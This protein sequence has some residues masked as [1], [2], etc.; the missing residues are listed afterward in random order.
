MKTRNELELYLHIPFCVRKCHYCDFLSFAADERTQQD[1]AYAL[2]Q[3]I[4]YYGK[5]MQ[6]REVSTIY[7]GGGTPSWLDADLLIRILDTVFKNF[8]VSVN[9]EISM[10]CNPGTIT[11]EKMGDYRNAGINRL[12]IGL[13]SADDEEL[14][15]LGRIHSYEQFLKTYELARNSH[16]SN[17]NVDVISGLPYQNY[18]KFHSTLQQVVRLKP[19]HIS[20]YTLIVEKGTP[21]YDQLKFDSVKQ[22]AGMPTEILPDEDEIYRI[23]KNTQSFLKS[24]GYEQYETSNFARPGFACRHNIGYWTRVN[25]L[26]LGLG[27]SS[28]IDNVRY[29]NVTDVYEYIKY[30]SRIDLKE[31][32]YRSYENGREEERMVMG[33]NLHATGEILTRTQQMEEFMFLGLRMNEGVRRADFEEA[34]GIPIDGVYGQVLSELREE[35]LMVVA[36]GRIYLTDKGM[37]L[38][39]YCMSKFLVS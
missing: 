39:N 35:E 34:F 30:A 16:F 36:A 24:M 1:Y 3:E 15:M 20:A 26:G 19:E 18:E 22:Q 33:T 29:S 17:I 21:F 38:A 32:S 8:H 10:E 11:R 4:S 27:A 25:Y 12:S 9:A 13:Q 2:M 28:L 37:D 31:L 7:I 6:D 23:M 14:K 5:L